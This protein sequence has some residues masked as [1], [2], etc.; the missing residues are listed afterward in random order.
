MGE[1]LPTVVLDLGGETLRAG[2]IRSL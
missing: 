1:E 2:R